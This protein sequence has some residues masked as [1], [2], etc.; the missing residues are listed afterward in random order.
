MTGA[1]QRCAQSPAPGP[2]RGPARR[3]ARGPA[4]RLARS[5]S[6][7]LT[8]LLF[9]VALP[10]AAQERVLDFHSDIRVARDGTLT[11]TERIDVQVEGQQIKRGILRDFPTDYRDSAGARSTVPFEMVSVRRD[12]RAEPWQQERLSNGVRVRIGNAAQMLPHGRHVYEI[13]Y[14]TSRQL[15]FFRDHDELYWNVNGNGWTFGMDRI[16]AEVTLPAAVP[17]EKLQLEAYTGLQGERGRDYEAEAREGGASFYTTRSMRAH[18][19]LTIVVAFPKGIIEEPGLAKRAGWW[20]GDN[21]GGAAGIGALVLLV[22]FLWWR[23][24][25]VGRDPR[26][27][28]AFPRYVAPPGLGPAAVRFI[29]RMNYDAKCLAA[30][31][32][33]LGARGFLKIRQAGDAYL[34]ERTGKEPAEWLP[35]E[36]TLAALVPSH[37]GTPVT[38]SK[39]HNPAVQTVSGLMA[40]ELALLYQEKLFSRNRGSHAAGVGIGILG[41]VAMFMLDAPTAVAAPV[42]ILMVAVAL[43]FGKVLPA[44][45]V[46]GRKLEDAIVGLR[47]YL[48]IAEKDDLARLKAPPQTPEEF[49]KFLPYAVALDVEEAWTRRFTAILGAAAVAAAAGEFYSSGSGSGFSGSGLASSL[50]GLG[51]TVSAASTPPGSSSGMSG[52]GGGGGGGSSGGGGGGGGGSGW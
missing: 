26:A 36:R 47:Q 35:G 6:A 25:L 18:Y 13:T 12:E 29:H 44:Y 23:W 11:V 8:F 5:L 43:F 37:A 46:D 32:V 27:G 52:G 14:R 38:L 9:A 21:E 31:L 1:T 40:R 10:G 41:A 16:A 48:S 28:P 33:G 20:L 7:A 30:G 4:W 15:G 24:S 39:E 19:G 42:I 51:D 2:A 34:V 22:A 17:A 3:L 49:T 45:S 50:G